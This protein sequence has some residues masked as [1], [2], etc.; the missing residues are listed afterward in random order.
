M[1][2]MKR[3]LCSVGLAT[4]ASTFGAQHALGSSGEFRI[5]R[6]LVE[7]GTYAGCA[8][9]VQPSPSGI[10]AGC[11]INWLSAGCNGEHGA[12]KSEAAQIWE[13]L[14]MAYVLDQPVLAVFGPNNV[15][16]GK[17][18]ITRVDLVKP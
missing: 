8:V 2:T 16:N 14:Q 15:V 3:L 4:L 12:S 13:I 6:M 11:G 10:D 9:A 7:P 1:Q 17:C 18:V 5:T